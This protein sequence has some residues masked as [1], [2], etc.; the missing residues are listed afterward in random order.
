VSRLFALALALAACRAFDASTAD[1]PPAGTTEQPTPIAKNEHRAADDDEPTGYI[2]VLAPRETAEIPAPFTSRTVTLNVK[3]GDPVKKGDTLGTLDDRTLRDELAI[4]KA[5]LKSHQAQVAQASVEHSAAAARLERERKALKENVSSPADVAAAGFDRSKAGTMVE[6]ALADVEEQKA[7]IDEL[8]K[9]LG[10][11]TLV[12]PIDGKVAL[13]YAVDG[14]RVTEGE[15]ILRVIT[16]DELFVKFAIP[17][18]DAKKL[19]PGDAIDV[20]IETSG[21]DLQGTV[22]NVAPELDPVA[23]MILAEAELVKPPAEIQAGLVCRITPHVA[24]KPP[25]K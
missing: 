13:I 25:A 12:A 16:S 15:P 14:A 17:A 19:A 1:P 11:A 9:Q 10:D 23:Q 2:G 6:R 18:S 21:L 8:E 4:A 22:R 3:L 20:H 24:A 5:S 7:K